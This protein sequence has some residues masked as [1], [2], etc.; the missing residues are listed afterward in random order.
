MKNWKHYTRHPENSDGEM[1]DKAIG[2]SHSEDEAIN[3]LTLNPNGFI[4]SPK[5][6]FTCLNNYK[7]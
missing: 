3:W 6:L 1:I 7:N 2:Y 4:L 5:G